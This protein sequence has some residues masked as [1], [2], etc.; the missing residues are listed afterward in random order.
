MAIEELLTL[1]RENKDTEPNEE[2]IKELIQ[3]IN[4][5]SEEAERDERYLRSSE[6]WNREYTL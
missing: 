1:V 6:F 2:T 4:R 5:R 3:K